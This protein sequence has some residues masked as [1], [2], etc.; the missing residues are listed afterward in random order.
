[1]DELAAAMRQ[2]DAI[3]K[4]GL[5]AEELNGALG[6]VFQH[7]GEGGQA[8]SNTGFNAKYTSRYRR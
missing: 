1:M 7:A 2:L 8:R 6:E 3:L 5:T 4:P